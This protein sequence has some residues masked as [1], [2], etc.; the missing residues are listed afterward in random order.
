MI[1]QLEIKKKKILSLSMTKSH[2][3]E[4]T[5]KVY[6]NHVDNYVDCVNSCLNSNF[7]HQVDLDQ[8]RQ[9]L[10]A[11]QGYIDQFRLNVVKKLK[12][13]PKQKDLKRHLGGI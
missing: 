9:F 11:V 7:K 12:N 5:L 6:I 2:F 10:L 3:D 13:K 8:E 4:D 1:E